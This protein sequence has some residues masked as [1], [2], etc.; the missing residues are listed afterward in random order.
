MVRV[1]AVVGV[2]LTLVAVFDGCG[3]EGGVGSPAADC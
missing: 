2:R 3:G 1:V